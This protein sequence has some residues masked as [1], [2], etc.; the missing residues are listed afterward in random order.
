MNNATKAALI[1]TRANP[2]Y[3]KT[4]LFHSTPFLDRRRRH[5]YWG[6]GSGKGSSKR[7]SYN[8]RGFRNQ[9]LKQEVLLNVSEFAEHLLQSWQNDYDTSSS[10]E[11][12]W[13]HFN[14]DPRSSRGFT[15][16]RN[17]KKGR[18][19]WSK[20]NFEFCEDEFEVETI[21]RSFGGGNKNCYWSFTNEEP[22]RTSSS[23][24]YYKTSWNSSNHYYFEDEDEDENGFSSDSDSDKSP[25][26]HFNLTKHRA[27]LGLKASGPLNLDDVKNAYR[28][29]ALKWHPDRH[30]GS[31]KAVAEEKFKVCSAAYQSLC[32]K[33]AVN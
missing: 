3:L 2:F 25:K 23:N 8:W 31:S 27:T 29:C 17:N 1:N 20:R 26:S 19:T 14:P 13:F 4:A 9:N 15:E 12:S 6:E 22:K 30:P 33:L 18:H 16:G 5:N 28:A 10:Q 11:S 21:F 24:S 32:K 7:K